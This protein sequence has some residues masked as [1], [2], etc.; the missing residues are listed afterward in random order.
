M[1]AVSAQVNDIGIIKVPLD[2]LNSFSLRWEAINTALSSDPSIK[3]VYICTP[4]NPT[5]NLISKYDIQRVLENPTWNGVVVLDEAYIDFAADGSSLAQWVNEWPNLVVMQTLSKG[6]GLAG[7]RLGVAFTSP[8]I[9][10]LLNNVKAPYNISGPTSSLAKAALQL[11]N[12]K[13]MRSKRDRILEQRERLLQELPKIPG[14]GRILGGWDSNFVLVEILD[15][16]SNGTP[17]NEVAMAV[18]TTLAESKG[19]VVRFR[20]KEFGC[21]GCLR[22]TVGTVTEVD[23][24]LDV[25]GKVLADMLEPTRESRKADSREQMASDIVA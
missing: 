8:E 7:V 25:V 1:Y 17:S 14:I 3:L 20:G 12:L 9:A 13:V 21:E 6:F 22:I 23:T 11:Q 4:G 5:G 2:P 15:N 18:Y 10:T 24:V 16:A 19:I